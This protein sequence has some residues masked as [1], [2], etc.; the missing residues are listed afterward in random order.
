MQNSECKPIKY[1]KHKFALLF[2]T[3]ASSFLFDCSFV[4]VCFLFL[5]AMNIRNSINVDIS[6]VFIFLKLSRE[7]FFFI[8]FAMNLLFVIFYS[9]FPKMAITLFYCNHCLCTIIIGVS[10]FDPSNSSVHLLFTHTMTH[11]NIKAFNPECSN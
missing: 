7:D 11:Q 2:V 4:D 1:N 6:F 5:S 9:R 8:V 10:W 3:F